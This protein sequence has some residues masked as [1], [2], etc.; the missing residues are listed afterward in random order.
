MCSRSGYVIKYPEQY[1]CKFSCTH[2]ATVS[3][4]KKK[5]KL[6]KNKAPATHSQK[7]LYYISS[8]AIPMCV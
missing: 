6:K 2:K 4:K 8:F 7:D 5:K 3:K 1:S